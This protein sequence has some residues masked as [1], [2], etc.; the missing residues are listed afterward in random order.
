MKTIQ[1][2]KDDFFAAG[3]IAFYFCDFESGENEV[4]DHYHLLK[5]GDEVEAGCADLG[6]IPLLSEE[7][8][9]ILQDYI[10]GKP[11]VIHSLVNTLL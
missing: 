9:S 6:R 8:N 3:Y 5:P 7:A 1:T 4:I 11:I 2:M 10:D